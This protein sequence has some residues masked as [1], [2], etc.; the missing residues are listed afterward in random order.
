MTK[1]PKRPRDLNQW[2]KRMVGIATGEIEDSEK[3]DELAKAPPKD[4]KRKKPVAPSQ[5]DKS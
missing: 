3:T 1:T 2:A 5:I 4:M